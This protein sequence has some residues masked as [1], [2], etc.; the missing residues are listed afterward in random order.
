[1][2]E[3]ANPSV[4]RACDEKLQADRRAAESV[5]CGHS[6]QELRC[7]MAHVDSCWHLFAAGTSRAWRA[8]YNSGD[9]TRRTSAGAAL[10]SAST[11]HWAIEAGFQDIHGFEKRVCRWKYLKRHQSCPY[12]S[13]VCRALNPQQTL[14]LCKQNGCQHRLSL[15][16]CVELAVAYGTAFSLKW[17]LDHK[18]ELM[19]S[20]NDSAESDTD[21]AQ[22]SESEMFDYDVSDEGLSRQICRLRNDAVKRGNIEILQVLDEAGL[23]RHHG[24][25]EGLDDPDDCDHDHD[26]DDDDDDDD[27]E[28]SLVGTACDHDQLQVAE[29]LLT[30][31]HDLASKYTPGCDARGSPETLLWLRERGVTIDYLG[32]ARAAAR[33][34]E[35][36]DLKRLHSMN[37]QA[38][39]EAD[40]TGLMKVASSADTI[41]WL[42]TEL[43]APLH[44]MCCYL[45]ARKGDRELFEW[46]AERDAPFAQIGMAG[47]AASSGQLHLV[48]H[49]ISIRVEPWTADDW[50][51]LVLAAIH[52]GHLETCDWVY[53]QCIPEERTRSTAKIYHATGQSNVSLS[54]VQ[55]AVE[56]GIEWKEL[57]GAYHWWHVEQFGCAMLHDSLSCEA[58]HWG[59]EHGIPCTCP[60]D[61]EYD[62]DYDKHEA[63]STDAFFRRR[64]V[65]EE[66]S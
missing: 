56:H 25:I 20:L 22:D 54:T 18:A 48:K 31:G 65:T 15:M 19:H 2:A 58:Y 62:E 42:H 50:H 26:D 21:S 66:R 1:M 17:L 41:R 33:S 29:W 61:G 32:F 28:N 23:F 44:H 47:C 35:L 36:Q 9:K 16:E 3:A 30:H 6:L 52:S 59:H 53:K 10:A 14:A 39:T 55:W 51:D 12:S 13:R 38:W 49:I 7:I 24:F 40:L 60:M 37:P 27:A 11:T 4:K 64:L 46:L 57:A 63:A 5:L 34:G 43:G 45:A 8:A